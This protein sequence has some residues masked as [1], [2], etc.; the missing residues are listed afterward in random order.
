MTNKPTPPG[1]IE[2][3]HLEFE[4]DAAYRAEVQFELDAAL[5]QRIVD[6]APVGKQKIAAYSIVRGYFDDVLKDVRQERITAEYAISLL[7]QMLYYRLINQQVYGIH[8]KKFAN[9]AVP[10]QPGN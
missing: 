2:Q 3:I 1:T 5:R 10:T 4:L 9:A 6:D 8:C 7:G